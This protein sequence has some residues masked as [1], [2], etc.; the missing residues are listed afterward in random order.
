M[1]ADF[2]DGV[3]CKHCGYSYRYGDGE[4]KFTRR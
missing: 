4:L 1:K 2:F 3:K